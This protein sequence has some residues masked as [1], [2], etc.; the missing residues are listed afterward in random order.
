[1]MITAG[2]FGNVFRVAPPIIISKD[3]L[4]IGI[5]IFEETIKETQSKMT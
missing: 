3:Q 5:D 1:M 4:D 2:M